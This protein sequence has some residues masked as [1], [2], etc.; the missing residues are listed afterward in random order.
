MTS[1]TV[2]FVDANVPEYAH[3]RRHPVARDLLTRL[4]EAQVAGATVLWTED[5]GCCGH[6]V[7]P[8]MTIKG[9]DENEKFIGTANGYQAAV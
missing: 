7:A 9:R 8:S 1:M 6:L 2:E 5:L 4:T 3:N